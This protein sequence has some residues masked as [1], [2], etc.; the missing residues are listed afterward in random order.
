MHNGVT[1]FAFCDGSVKVISDNVEPDLFKALGTI[2][3]RE[4]VSVGDL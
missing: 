4:R 3:G 1:S 2:R